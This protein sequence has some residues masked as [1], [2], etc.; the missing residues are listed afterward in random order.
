MSD[1]W[2]V[3]SAIMCFAL[4]RHPHDKKMPLGDLQKA[5]ETFSVTTLEELNLDNST[6][7]PSGKPLDEI[8]ALTDNLTRIS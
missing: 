5:S 2:N 8:S 3:T 1:Q 4:W 6:R 7:L